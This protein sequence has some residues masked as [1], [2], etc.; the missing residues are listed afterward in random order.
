MVVV[1][2]GQALEHVVAAAAVAAAVAAAAV[3]CWPLA[4]GHS[5]WCNVASSV[6]HNKHQQPQLLH[7]L[8]QVE[9][10]AING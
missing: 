2:A 8:D 7:L 3:A 9:C 6:P 10:C 1:A 4:K 5:V